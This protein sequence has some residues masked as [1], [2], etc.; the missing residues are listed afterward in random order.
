MQLYCGYCG[1]F[2][3]FSI[4]RYCGGDGAEANF[5]DTVGLYAIYGCIFTCNFVGDGIWECFNAKEQGGTVQSW[6]RRI[7]ANGWG[8]CYGK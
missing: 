1:V 4:K 3:D 8:A 6:H 7:H 5:C 2:I